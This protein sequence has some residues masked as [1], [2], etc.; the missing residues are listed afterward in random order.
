MLLID[1]FLKGQSR[2]RTRE[3]W[4][5]GDYGQPGLR[6]C[7]KHVDGWLTLAGRPGDAA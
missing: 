3:K 5:A 6:P 1:I 2:E 7:A 4:T